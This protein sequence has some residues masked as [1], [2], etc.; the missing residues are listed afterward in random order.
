MQPAPR[1]GMQKIVAF[2]VSISLGFVITAFSASAQST[3]DF[4]ETRVRPVLAG[5][6]YGCHAEVRR[7]GL[8]LNSLEAFLAGGSTGPA[9]IPGDPDNSLLIQVVRHEIADLEMRRDEE[10]LSAREIEGLAEWIRMDAPWPAEDPVAVTAAANQGLSLGALIFVDRVRPVLERGG[11]RL[12]SRD[13]MLQGGG[14]GPAIL[15]G[16]PEQS[17]LIAALRHESDDLQMPRNADPLTDREIQGFVEWI[18]AGAEWADVAAPIVLPR[19]AVTDEERGFW[20]FQG[21]THPTVPALP[22]DEWAKTDIGPPLWSNAWL[23]AIHQGKFI[24]DKV[25]RLEEDFDPYDLI[26]NIH[27]DAVELDDQRREV[28]LVERLNRLHLEC[29]GQQDEQI[30]QIEGAID[31]MEIAYRM[32]TEAPDVFDIRKETAATQELY[33]PGSTARGCLMAVRLIDQGV[34]MVQVY[35][36]KGDPWDHHGDIMKHRVNALHS[37]QAFAAVIKDLKS[38]GL[39]EETLVVCGTEFGRTPVLE[40]GG[41]G[42]MGR[43]TNG[44]DHN[45]FGFSVWLAGGGVKGGM[46]Y[47]STDDFGFRAVENPVYIHDLHATILHLMGIDHENL[48][49]N[50]SGRD[51]RLTDVAGEVIHDIIA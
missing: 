37:D 41:G 36:E 14:R 46:T 28:D 12:D 18:R 39:F 22:S 30:E 33:G 19:R 7:G 29:L 8:R 11:L 1:S 21:L 10:R 34:R 38:R 47:G 6:W 2:S 15:P 25:P 3:D 23:P 49:Y 4:F 13:R 42:A 35:Y 16:N 24:P 32:Q 50:Y 27:T 5:K 51:F 48:T 26:P 45:P 40:T 9:I 17:L 20:S 43:V 44:R 31:A